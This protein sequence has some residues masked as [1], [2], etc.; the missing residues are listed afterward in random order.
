M[1]KNIKKY[2]LL[3]IMIIYCMFYI[4]NL[5][6]WGLLVKGAWESVESSNKEIKFHVATWSWTY[7]HCSDPQC[8][9]ALLG[10]SD[11]NIFYVL[12]ANEIVTFGREGVYIYHIEELSYD[13][14][15]IDDH[16][17]KHEFEM[18]GYNGRVGEWFKDFFLY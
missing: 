13:K 6:R 11:A 8:E 4:L 1:I 7:S 18:K 10:K 14:L 16:G 5:F 15:I 12:V 9:P 3:T 17:E 2:I